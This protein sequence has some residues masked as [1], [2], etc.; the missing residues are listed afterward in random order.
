MV[1]VLKGTTPLG[2][3][4]CV[5]KIDEI[6]MS[7]KS[8]RYRT[9]MHKRTH[10]HRDTVAVHVLITP[11]YCPGE[12]SRPSFPAF[13]SQPPASASAPLA[14]LYSCTLASS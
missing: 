11:I 8:D 2:E 1:E 12:T 10:T 13:D 14:L 6:G 3:A 5:M 4:T 9:N 7:L